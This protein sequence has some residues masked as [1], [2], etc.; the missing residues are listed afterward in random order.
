[1]ERLNGRLAVAIFAALT[2]VVVLQVVNRV[3]LHFPIIWSEE[4]ARFLFLWVVMLGAA[5]SVKRRRHFVLDVLPRRAGTERGPL[6]LL[7]DMV[8]DACV[9]A[10]AVFLVVQG[11]IYVRAGT[12]RTGTNSEINMSLVY[13]AIPVFAAL[14]LVYSIRNL[15]ADYRAWR[16]GD[17]IHP[18][19]PPAE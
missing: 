9:L 11:T 6:A 17:A 12:F 8:P 18:T 3:A 19:P 4:V 2:G 14:T 10:F 7:V 15:I 16:A 13:A 5:L 1:M